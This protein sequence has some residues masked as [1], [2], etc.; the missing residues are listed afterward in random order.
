MTPADPTA[1]TP[2]AAD[3]AAGSTTGA[4]VP[5]DL[6]AVA[7]ALPAAWS[8]RLLGQVGGAAVKV[9]RMD[10]RT[11][12]T[13]HHPTAEALLV[14]DGRLE[15]VVDGAEST[16]GPGGL[17]WVPAG[18]RHAVRPGSHGTLVIVEVPEG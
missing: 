14:L 13:E 7:A 17:A 9:L 8:S 16:V 11:L 4:P 12:D 2:S 6:A 15:L 10:G 18:A 5:V 3:P 1:V